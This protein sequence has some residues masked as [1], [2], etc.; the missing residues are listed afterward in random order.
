MI[1]EISNKLAV[2]DWVKDFKNTPVCG[3]TL[4][5]VIGRF[6]SGQCHGIFD[7]DDTG[8]PLWFCFYR[9]TNEYLWIDFL[10]APNQ[11][12][13][14]KQK[15]FFVYLAAKHGT[16]KIRFA[17]QRPDRLWTRVLPG[18]KKLWSVYE[19]EL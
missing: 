9:V 6:L 3:E 8:W 13:T 11:T 12:R 18:A 2:C 19:Y 5:L 17:S 1:A 10:W 7:M 14:E 15:Q 4:E 16:K